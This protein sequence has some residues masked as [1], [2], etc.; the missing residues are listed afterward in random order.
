MTMRMVGLIAAG[1]AAALMLASCTKG[2]DAKKSRASAAAGTVVTQ[3]TVSAAQPEFGK[4]VVEQAEIYDSSPGRIALAMLICRLDSSYDYTQLVGKSAKELFETL[5]ETAFEKNVTLES[6]NTQYGLCDIL[7]SEKIY[8]SIEANSVT[9]LPAPSSSSSSKPAS[10][11]PSRNSS[12]VQQRQQ[13]SST[14]SSPASSS[15]PSS[16][17]QPSSSS[18]GADSSSAPISS[19]PWAVRF[20]KEILRPAD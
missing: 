8:V 12:N 10:S 16:S 18:G 6:L 4:S 3:G 1:L 7:A 20:E 11:V 15:A 14:N 9:S 17:K 19:V 2:G 13:P 5:S